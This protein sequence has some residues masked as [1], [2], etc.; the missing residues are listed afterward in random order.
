MRM[1]FDVLP[2]SEQP[3]S[4]SARFSERWRLAG[5]DEKS[6]MDRIVAG[7]RGLRAG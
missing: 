3:L 5:T 4:G 6:A 2:E 1:R 7:L